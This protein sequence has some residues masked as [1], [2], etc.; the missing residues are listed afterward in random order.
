[1][2][3]WLRRKLWKISVRKAL[4]VEAK[5]KAETEAKETRRLRLKARIEEIAEDMKVVGYHPVRAASS[6][7]SRY[8]TGY[9]TFVH[10]RTGRALRLKIDA[11]RGG[12]FATESLA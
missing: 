10:E 1:M 2:I 5:N 8:E 7:D 11:D 12:V 3:A 9:A 4:D 6:A